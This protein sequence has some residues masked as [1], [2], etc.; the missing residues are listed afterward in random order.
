[1]KELLASVL[2]PKLMLL[3]NMQGLLVEKS[4]K[5]TVLVSFP[6]RS[7]IE[8]VV[9]G[10]EKADDIARK[11]LSVIG[12]SKS[13]PTL[14]ALVCDGTAVNTGKYNGVIRKIELHLGRPL[15]WLIC[16]MHANELP[17]RK[18]L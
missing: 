5:N 18:L 2:M 9:P 13:E 3:L 4:K 8:H 14:R 6:S 16:S 12:G 10:S 17:W 7:Y 15:Q 11:I 1:M